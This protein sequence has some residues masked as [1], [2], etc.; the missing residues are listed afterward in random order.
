M[1]WVI[2]LIIP[3]IFI[4]PIFCGRCDERGKC[5]EYGKCGKYGEC[6][7]CGDAI[8]FQKNSRS[9][10]I[11]FLLKAVTLHPNMLFC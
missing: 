10:I 1:L 9:T 7:K 2:A 3:I 6:G 8:N 5:S 11:T 4:M